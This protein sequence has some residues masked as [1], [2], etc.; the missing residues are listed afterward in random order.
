MCFQYLQAIQRSNVTLKA[1]RKVNMFIFHYHIGQIFATTSSLKKIRSRIWH[2][3][4]R[5]WVTTSCLP[6]SGRGR[7]EKEERDPRSHP[8]YPSPGRRI[9]RRLRREKKE[10]GKNISLS[11]NSWGRSSKKL[12][13]RRSNYHK[14]ILWNGTPCFICCAKETKIPN[15]TLFMQLK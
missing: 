3:P 5:S 6:P 10:N 15:N 7:G 9:N 13:Q 14:S 1:K 12:F 4:S 2:P 8:P 11:K